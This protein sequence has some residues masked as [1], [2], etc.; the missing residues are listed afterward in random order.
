[1]SR[2][3][4]Q[5]GCLHLQVSTSTGMS[6]ESSSSSPRNMNVTP[7][8]T[9]PIV[10]G[11]LVTT[12]TS[13]HWMA[14]ATDFV[15]RELIGDHDHRNIWL[16]G[17]SFCFEKFLLGDP[18]CDR[19]VF[20]PPAFETVIVDP[21]VGLKLEISARSCQ[22]CIELIRR[23]CSCPGFG[24]P[25]RSQWCVQD[26]RRGR[27]P[28]LVQGRIGACLGQYKSDCLAYQ[29]SLLFWSMGEPKVDIACCFRG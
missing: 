21:T 28:E 14:R 12:S 10:C 5:W 29:Y 4:C 17:T 13:D 9:R 16:C 23:R 15:V 20:D 6:I 11:L 1:M 7:Q 18:S 24:W 19:I 26:W 27:Q 22:G 8:K 3:R 25:W 2:E